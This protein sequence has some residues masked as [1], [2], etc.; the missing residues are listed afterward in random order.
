MPARYEWR[1]LK[2][3][4]DNVPKAIGFVYALVMIGV[5]A[6]LWHSGRWQRSIGWLLLLEYKKTG[7]E[8]GA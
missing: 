4:F 1:I 2:M 8:S 6:Y 3:V 5:L 7:S